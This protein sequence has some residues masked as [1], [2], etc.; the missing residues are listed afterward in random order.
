MMSEELKVK[1]RKK[2][3]TS[4]KSSLPSSFNHGEL[5]ANWFEVEESHTFLSKKLDT[6]E[7][8]VG[9]VFMWEQW[10]SKSSDLW[11][12]CHQRIFKL[13]LWCLRY[14]HRSKI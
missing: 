14:L 12:N 1:E 7:F 10:T 13:F 11:I 5:S 8:F 9:L 4:E 3:E 2:E 6:K